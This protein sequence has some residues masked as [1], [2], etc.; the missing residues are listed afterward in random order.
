MLKPVLPPPAVARHPPRVVGP[1]RFHS[2]YRSPMWALMLHWPTWA[3]ACRQTGKAIMSVTA[4]TTRAGRRVTFEVT[5]ASKSMVHEIL[6]VKIADLWRFPMTPRPTASTKTRLEAWV[7]SELDAGTVA[8]PHARTGHVP[9][10][11]QPARP[12]HGRHVDQHHR[13]LIAVISPR[14]RPCQKTRACPCRKLARA[15]MDI[16]RPQGQE[17]GYYWLRT[18]VVLGEGRRIT[19][20][21]RS[22]HHWTS[23]I[24]RRGDVAG[25]YMRCHPPR[26]Q[27]AGRQ[28]HGLAQASPA[29]RRHSGHIT[30][31][32]DQL[33]TA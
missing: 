24:G 21:S 9:A 10:L 13:E 12:L 8:Y 14:L 2:A 28:G 11:L 18:T 4:D 20:R 25:D 30:T 3:W 16:L 22:R 29:W 23:H 26:P 31:A 15:S 5:N 1:G 7:V 32:L 6:V 27:P 19:S 17:C 33:S